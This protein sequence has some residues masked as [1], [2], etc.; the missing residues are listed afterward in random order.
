MT[1]ERNPE[2]PAKAPAW[3]RNDTAAGARAYRLN[4]AARALAEAESLGVNLR[5]PFGLGPAEGLGMTPEAEAE[6]EE[7]DSLIYGRAFALIL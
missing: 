2:A 6:A 3:A 5:D 1:P 4:R 7:L